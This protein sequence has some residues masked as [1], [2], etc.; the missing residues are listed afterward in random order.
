MVNKDDIK[1]SILKRIEKTHDLLEK[2]KS[3]NTLAY[4]Q[5]LHSIKT[6]YESI[7]DFDKAC[8]YAYIIIDLLSRNVIEYERNPENDELVNDIWVTA[9]DT[10]ARQGDFESFCI[11]MEWNRPINKQFYLP[12]AKLLKKHGVIQG[13]QDLIDDKL[14]LLV[15]NLPP[16]IGKNLS[17]STPILTKNG[18]KKH[19]D[20]QVG[21]YV[22][23]NKGR[24]VK[25][26]ATSPEYPCNC[27]VTFA[28]G[29]QIDCH[30]NHEWL[31]N[32]RH[33]NREI[34]IETKSMIDKVRDD[35]G[36]NKTKNHFRFGLPIIEPIVGEYKSLPVE[37][38]CFGVWLGDGTNKNNCI[39]ISKD[40]TIIA[41]TFNKYY[42]ISTLY[43]HKV[44][45]TYRYSF[46]NLRQDLQKIDMCYSGKA[47]IKHI[48]DM[49]LT[50]SIEQRL[51]L[52]AGLLDT[53]GTLSKKE[54]RY[55]YSTTEKQLMEDFV[56]LIS[57]FGWRCSVTEY[58]PTLSSSG[59]QGR[60]KVYSIGFNPTFEIPCRVPRKQLK[61]FS[62]PRRI[63]I[64][65]IEKIENGEMGKCIQV[66]GGIYLA[67]KTL[68]P[69]H[70]STIGLFLQVLLG[71]MCPDESI[72]GSGHTTGLIDSFYDEIINF[73]T[74]DEYRYRKIFPMNNIV[75]KSSEYHYLDLNKKKRFHTFNYVS[76]E[77]GGT[78]KVQAERLLYCDDLVKDVEQANNPDRLEKLYHNYTSTIKDRKIQRLCK[79][80]VYRPCPEI[81]INTPWSLYDVTSRVV[82][83]AKIDGNMD[84]VRIISVPCYDENGNSNFEYDY[85]KGFNA[86]YYKDMELA[87]DPVI[88]SAKYLMTPVERDGLVFNRENVSFYYN[89][90]GEKPDMIVGYADVTHGGD[91]YFSLP[92]GYVYGTE[93]Y[94]EDVLFINKFGGD[95]GSRPFVRDIIIRNKATRVGVEKNN[96][97]DFYSTLM[98]QD[99]ADVGYRCHI[100]TH[101]APTN[102]AKRDRILACQ[103]EIKGI[104][105]E[106]NT[107]RIYFKHPDTIKGNIQYQT[108]MQNLYKWNQNITAQKKQ[109]DD[110]PDSLAGLITN[111]LG[112]MKST[113]KVYD[114]KNF[115]I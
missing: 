63:T 40:D 69:T 85:G 31:V 20:L 50:S 95:D 39:T 70:N 96:G 58:E 22:L 104:A 26:L 66:E 9:Y 29:E 4:L 13:V 98:Q 7:E 114:A 87:E 11:A 12:R 5:G 44:C 97:G 48:P 32:D 10:R 53:D 68:L 110:F 54:H 1:T 108:A 67:G 57:T 115:G 106:N 25:V 77:T 24:F 59:I 102:K 73:M 19:G 3:K 61:V 38:Y 109:H 49:Y 36:D 76:I 100:T 35:Y 37:P 14:D 101:N 103:N 28:N 27:R 78:G 34:V 17:N 81:H 107:Y 30:E 18:W 55:H 47:C 60:K 93:V 89:L 79:D 92:I 105:T 46:S 82:E 33:K 42:P 75:D 111:V 51:Q 83:N 56:S 72:L 84:R 52:L 80:G 65:N 64:T 91:D 8:K 23:N 21:D 99:L 94:V 113:V 41:E 74:D 71:S 45:G 86:K 88:F 16:R 112:G 62:K 90:P 6:D 15:L 2:L 43:I